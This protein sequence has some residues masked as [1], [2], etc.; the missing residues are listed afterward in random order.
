MDS[1]QL[2]STLA[3]LT[4]SLGDATRRGIYLMV[5]ASQEPVTV[6]DVAES[7]GI[8]PN[9]ARHHLDR[10]ASDGYVKVSSPATARRPTGA[11]RP[12]KAYR[13]TSKE[14]DLHFP[15][16]RY[17]LLSELLVM[18]VEKVAPE[19]LADVAREVGRDYGRALASR[20]DTHDQK[21]FEAAVKA[22]AGAMR[23]VGFEMAAHGERLVTNHCPFGTTATDH[24]DLICSLDQGMV[25]GMMEVF[26]HEVRPKI[27]PHRTLEEECVTEVPVTITV[28]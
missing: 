13:A 15:A 17:D 25:T 14:I 23:G 16:Q 8:H 9:V 27:Y 5:R 11:G 24:P 21:G 20:L 6:S 18:V 26:R 1:R 4:S 10:L 12:A 3:D 22:V 19:N 7:F 28:R 2:D